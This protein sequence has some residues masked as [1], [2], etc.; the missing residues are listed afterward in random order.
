MGRGD[1]YTMFGRV[2]SLALQATLCRQHPAGRQK[3]KSLVLTM[4]S[5]KKRVI[6]LLCLGVFVG[7]DGLAGQRLFGEAQTV[8][9]IVLLSIIGIAVFCWALSQRNV[10]RG[11]GSGVEKRE[12]ALLALVEAERHKKKFKDFMR[13]IR[14]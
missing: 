11:C 7:L 12:V 13:R 10:S 14:P 3:L 5:L 9:E 6:F 4:T 8:V 1:D 2:L